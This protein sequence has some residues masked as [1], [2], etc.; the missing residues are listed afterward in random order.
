M[1]AYISYSLNDSERYIVTVLSVKLQEQGFRTDLSFFDYKSE[2]NYGTKS[3][4]NTS[5][6]FIGILTNDGNRVN[7]VYNE[8]LH[9]TD[10]NIPS[11]L[12]I[13]DE[14]L[15]HNLNLGSHPNIVQFNRSFPEDAIEL[16]NF[17]VQEAKSAQQGKLNNAVAWML[18]GIATVAAIKLLSSPK[19]EVA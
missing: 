4:I 1:K 17:N 16:V 15:K 7:P 8:F 5:H 3:R 13:E 14:L 11:I 12:L 10:N 2:I 19:K 6:I 9:A 18:G